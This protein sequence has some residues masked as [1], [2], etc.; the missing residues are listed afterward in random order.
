MTENP[1]Q[2]QAFNDQA[3][4]NKDEKTLDNDQPARDNFTARLQ[5]IQLKRVPLSEIKRCFYDLHPE[6]L[7]YPDRNKFLRERLDALA[8]LNVIE[9]PAA[10]RKNWDNSSRPPLP[11]WVTQ[12]TGRL[13][14]PIDPFSIAWVPELSF[15]ARLRNR[16]QL[17]AAIK[18]NDYLINNRHLLAELLPLRERSLEIF[19]D[20]K[21]MDSMIINGHFFGGKLSLAAL[22]AV[23]VAAPIPF[24][25]SGHKSKRILIVENH[26]TYWSM[27]QWN[28][29]EPHY[30]AVV[31]GGGNAVLRN[32]EGVAQLVNQLEGTGID[33]FGDI[34]LRGLQ[35]L[36]ATITGLKTNYSID[37][38]AAHSF[39][40]WLLQ[41]GQRCSSGV[42]PEPELIRPT[43]TNFPAAAAGQ[44]VAL[45]ASG[46]RIPQE[47]LNSRQLKKHSFFT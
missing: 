45:I 47:S 42:S 26:H 2:I 23:S 18:I 24:E 1:V 30:S 25:F 14:Q 15:C 40:N 10:K 37:A 8:A 4:L 11:L 36:Q 13:L 29:S 27:C 33:Y 17:E 35:I 34:D 16:A 21:R 28:K 44:I 6:L 20:E 46:K 38:S 7:D 41:H 5:Q 19:G 3:A 31:W 43:I 32:I 22:G 12:R 9:F 39:Y